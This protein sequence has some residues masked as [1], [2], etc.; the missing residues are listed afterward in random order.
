M[1]SLNPAVVEADEPEAVEAKVVSRLPHLYRSSDMKFKTELE[2]MRERAASGWD[3]R[4]PYKPPGPLTVNV[5]LRSRRRRKDDDADDDR[6]D[7]LKGPCRIGI[8]KGVSAQ[9]EDDIHRVR[10]LSRYKSKDVLCRSIAGDMSMRD[11]VRR[12]EMR[13]RLC[14]TGCAFLETLSI[15]AEGEKDLPKPE[16]KS[17]LRLAHDNSESKG[18]GPTLRGVAAAA[19]FMH[20]ATPRNDE[21]DRD[22]SGGGGG[23]ESGSR[24]REKGSRRRMGGATVVG[25]PSPFLTQDATGRTIYEGGRPASQNAITDDSRTLL[26]LPPIHPNAADPRH[27]PV[28]LATPITTTAPGADYGDVSDDTDTD[29]G[30][31]LNRSRMND[32]GE[33]VR[34]MRSARTARSTRANSLAGS[35][36]AG[37]EPTLLR[38]ASHMHGEMPH[39][40]VPE[41]HTRQPVS[42][43]RLS[44]LAERS[45]AF[46]VSLLHNPNPFR[47][48][49]A[50]AQGLGVGGLSGAATARGTMG[51]SAI[52]GDKWMDQLNKRWRKQ[53]ATK[54]W[55]ASPRF[56]LGTLRVIASLPYEDGRPE[57]EKSTLDSLPERR[58][59]GQDID[60]QNRRP[61]TSSIDIQNF[62]RPSKAA[63]DP[64]IQLVGSC[65]D[66]Q[67]TREQLSHDLLRRVQHQDT[68][69]PVSYAQKY[70]ELAASGRMTDSV[71]IHDEIAR[72][73]LLAEREVLRQKLKNFRDVPWFPKLLLLL[74]EYQRKMLPCEMQLVHNIKT[75]AE[76][77]Q[78]FTLE[79]IEG[80]LLGVRPEDIH[81]TYIQKAF[82]FLIDQLK[83]NM[84]DFHGWMI[85]QSIPVPPLFEKAYQ[86]H[87]RMS[88]ERKY[89]I[90]GRASGRRAT[91]T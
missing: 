17:T 89:Q 66:F 69:R 75:I 42:R 5:R 40:A 26:S 41:A 35:T 33:S 28:F 64:C 19:T 88:Q 15:N 47:I 82:L 81:Q 22:D 29:A 80:L 2:R 67:T 51:D 77:G 63:L 53:A 18:S 32:D 14:R 49:I 52:G 31:E 87:V 78:A 57:H 54:M 27:N 72:V 58:A 12:S 62:L 59:H 1:Q 6:K 50:Q 10:A 79:M 76:E 37:R 36:D 21:H 73:Q 46:D 56:S 86:E 9:E 68:S 7:H 60:A 55:H 34:S 90:S 74:S 30:S 8:T 4:T 16:T 43:V 24:E 44:S 84:D 11:A 61:H 38:T 39:L 13:L 25:V 85:S 71:R 3:F 83:L 48:P 45:S 91:P 23:G 65:A 70:S 20:A